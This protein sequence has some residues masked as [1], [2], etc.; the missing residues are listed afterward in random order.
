MPPAGRAI[1]CVIVGR[2]DGWTQQ[3]LP[4]YARASSGM[5]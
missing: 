2:D 4:N 3:I 1:D 5:H